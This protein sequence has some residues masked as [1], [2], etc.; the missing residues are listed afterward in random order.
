MRRARVP[1]GDLGRRGPR[2]QNSRRH[3][4]GASSA[5]EG[6]AGASGGTG[7]CCR[8]LPW[9]ARSEVARRP[10]RAQATNAY[11][12]R[13]PA[14]RGVAPSPHLLSTGLSARQLR[15]RQ[16]QATT[17]VPPEARRS[18][19]MRDCSTGKP[20]SYSGTPP[21]APRKGFIRRRARRRWSAAPLRA[22]V[23]G[24]SRARAREA[25]QCTCAGFRSP[26]GEWVEPTCH[27][28]KAR[29]SS[30]Q[31]GGSTV[32]RTRRS[33]HPTVPMDTLT[34]VS[35]ET[36]GCPRR[37][38]PRLSSECASG[39]SRHSEGSILAYGICPQSERSAGREGGGAARSTAS[40]AGL[41]RGM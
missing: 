19:T 3:L 9:S 11:L 5:R 39:E 25:T 18:G 23:P 33:R 29:R 2:N 40:G 12:A 35:R 6:A 27:T 1:A 38:V 22:A 30:V 21:S 4:V 20:S 34:R 16:V 26:L 32:L 24:S 13:V 15:W 17:V 14:H 10:S 37:P 41:M 8:L 31:T 28:G 36:R 7:C